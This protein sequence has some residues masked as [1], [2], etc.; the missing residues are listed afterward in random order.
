LLEG[1]YE[2]VLAD[3][4]NLIAPFYYLY[5]L[6]LWADHAM[7]DDNLE[8]VAKKLGVAWPHDYQAVM[9]ALVAA[10]HA[11]ADKLLAK[12]GA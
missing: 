2:S 1:L 11:S 10:I 12:V 8:T 5:D 6:R 3:S 4:A 9:M 7:G